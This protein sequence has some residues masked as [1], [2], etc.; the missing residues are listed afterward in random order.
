ML[1]IHGAGSSFAQSR[2]TFLF[3]KKV[4]ESFFAIITCFLNLEIVFY[5]GFE[6]THGL[7]K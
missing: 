2:D 7:T 4:D 6:K 3:R 1:Q 5:W